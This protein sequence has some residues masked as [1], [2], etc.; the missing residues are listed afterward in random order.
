[1]NLH[2]AIL[3]P[4][5]VLEEA[6]EVVRSAVTALDPATAGGG[7]PR[8]GRRRGLLGRTRRPAPDPT[9]PLELDL[10]SPSRLN[11]PVANLGNVTNDDANRLSLA[12]HEAAAE[13]E[14]PTLC[15]GGATALEFP[16]DRSVWIKLD[17]DLDALRRI[18]PGVTNV[19]Q[20]LGFFV[21]RRVFHPWLSV[22]T[23]ND[24]TTAEGLEAIVGALERFRGQPWQVDH[25]SLMRRMLERDPPESC[26]LEQIY[27]GAP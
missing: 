13:L 19:V 5:S 20:R 7:S 8:E 24:A 23:I 22:G 3:P 27:L 16:T 11:L 14:R 18:G 1:M 15:L 9:R 21:D 12:L 25:V 4:S 10:I 6:A 26:E 2:V 17:G